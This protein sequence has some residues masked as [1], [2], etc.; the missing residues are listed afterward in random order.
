MVS[1]WKTHLFPLEPWQLLQCMG[2]TLQPRDRQS[3]REAISGDIAR[4]PESHDSPQF[5]RRRNLRKPEESG[6]DPRASLWWDMGTGQCGPLRTKQRALFQFEIA[7][8]T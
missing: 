7:T 3:G 5:G 1:R 6:H 4:Q 2:H 8:G